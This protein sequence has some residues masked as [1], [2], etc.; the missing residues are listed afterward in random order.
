VPWP[1]VAREVSAA[2]PSG[3]KTAAAK[4]AGRTA[5]SASQSSLKRDFIY[6]LTFFGRF[7]PWNSDSH[8]LRS[9]FQTHISE[10]SNFS[11]WNFKINTKNNNVHY[12]EG[13]TFPQFSL[14][15]KT[16]IKNLGCATPD[17]VISW[18]NTSRHWTNEMLR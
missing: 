15:E 10:C 16:A 7:I 14:T 8:F 6:L 11:S 13:I 9:S 18:H 3:G 4:V 1:E 2:R 12:L 17:L 5:G